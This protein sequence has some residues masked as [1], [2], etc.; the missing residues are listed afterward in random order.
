[1]AS[2]SGAWCRPKV[3]AA[4]SRGARAAAAAAAAALAGLAY[5]RPCSGALPRLL[6]RLAL[7]GR[8]CGRGVHVNSSLLTSSCV[9]SQVE[10][11][12]LENALASARHRLGEMRKIS[13]QEE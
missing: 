3:P 10:I 4:C 12:Q 9:D 2:V 5:E 7:G 6:E 13:Y 11:L 8:R 1:M